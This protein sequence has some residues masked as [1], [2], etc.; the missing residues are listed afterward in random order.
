MLKRKH[1]QLNLSVIGLIKKLESSNS[2]DKFIVKLK[3]IDLS[4]KSVKA[5]KIFEK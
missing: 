4:E 5:K 3:E 2:K 1:K